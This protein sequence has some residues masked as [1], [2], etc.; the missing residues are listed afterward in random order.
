MRDRNAGGCRRGECARDARHDVERNTGR[1]QRKRLLSATAEDERI[2]TLQPHDT[3]AA[4][5]G[6]NH[7]RM[8]VFLRERMAARTLADEKPLGPPCDLQ[9]ALVDERVVQHEISGPQARDRGPCQQTG[10]A[11]TGA[12]ERNVPF[13]G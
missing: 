7:H 9:N 8:D 10:I 5:R 4:L 13:H 11:G 2:A 3:A 12:D 6:A 1:L